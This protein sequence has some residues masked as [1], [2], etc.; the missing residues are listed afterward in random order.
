[1]VSPQT[2]DSDSYYQREGD[3][4]EQADWRCF[5]TVNGMLEV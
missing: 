5:R 2:S 4:V 1:M 3:T